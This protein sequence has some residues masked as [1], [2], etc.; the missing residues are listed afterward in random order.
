MAPTSSSRTTA[1]IPSLHSSQASTGRRQPRAESA[2][3][4]SAVIE[5]DEPVSYVR[6]PAVSPDGSRIVFERALETG[7]IWTMTLLAR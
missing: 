2:A 7:D 3:R 6:Y 5:R 1:G 4:S